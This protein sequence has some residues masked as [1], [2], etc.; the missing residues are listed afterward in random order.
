MGLKSRPCV[1]TAGQFETIAYTV[2]LQDKSD[3]IETLGAEAVGGNYASLNHDAAYDWLIDRVY[4]GVTKSIQQCRY[5]GFIQ[6]EHEK[7]MFCI[8]QYPLRWTAES[9]LY[10]FIPTPTRHM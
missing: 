10:L 7:G 8:A 6:S 1:A 4:I 2:L 5:D 9:A 3:M